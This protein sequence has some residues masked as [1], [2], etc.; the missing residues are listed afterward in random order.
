MFSC[1]NL[2]IKL[3]CVE[4]I[5]HNCRHLSTT[6]PAGAE[7]D[8]IAG[9]SDD[10]NHSTVIGEFTDGHELTLT[11]EDVEDHGHE[12]TVVE[13][14][15]DDSYEFMSPMEAEIE[16]GSREVTSVMEAKVQDDS[17]ELTSAVEAEIEVDGHELT[18][19]VEEIEDGSLA[20][21]MTTE[22]DGSFRDDA[23]SNVDSE[24]D[25]SE[26]N[27]SECKEAGPSDKCDSNECKGLHKYDDDPLHPGASITVKITM[28][29]ILT[30]V[31]RH[32][33]TNEVISDLLYL[34]NIFGPKSG[35]C[36]STLYKFKK[37]FD[38]LVTPLTFCYYCP[39]CVVLLITQ[40]IKFV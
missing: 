17:H 39:D 35:R 36:C 19:T 10:H 15:E 13:G 4:N 32:K 40:L 3:V 24:T 5:V 27:D 7:S 1:N 11:V 34:L 29:L 8:E 25:C 28:I 20:A 30:I 14:I 31:T 2:Q 21:E 6:S 9:D 12:L 22:D 26:T 18:S 37:Y 33:L 23:N 38:Y 16:N